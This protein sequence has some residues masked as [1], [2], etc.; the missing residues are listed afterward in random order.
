VTL[1]PNPV[2]DIMNIDLSALQLSGEVQLSIFDLNGKLLMS[3]RRPAFG[4]LQLNV[5]RFQTG[6]YLLQILND[7]FIIGKKFAIV[8]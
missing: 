3:Q 5:D 7:K 2:T 4:T 6:N 8:R 1:Y